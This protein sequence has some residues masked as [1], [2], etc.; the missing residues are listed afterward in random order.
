MTTPPPTIGEVRARMDELRPRVMRAGAA[1]QDVLEY[2]ALEDELD[3]RGGDRLA[4]AI[5]CQLGGEGPV[6]PFPEEP[7]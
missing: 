5:V 6:D 4:G 2:Q 7:C 1:R 3:A